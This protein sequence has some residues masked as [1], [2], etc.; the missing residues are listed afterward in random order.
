MDGG[1]NVECFLVF[2]ILSGSF[3]L[4]LFL[5]WYAN[6]QIERGKKGWR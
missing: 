5:A 4:A 3:G 6:R 1:V 2:L